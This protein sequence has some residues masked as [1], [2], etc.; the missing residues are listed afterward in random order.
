MNAFIFNGECMWYIVASQ[1]PLYHGRLVAGHACVYQES[2]SLNILIVYAQ[3]F[4][5]FWSNVQFLVPENYFESET[6][7]FS[8]ILFS[9]RII[10]YCSS[11]LRYN[12][13]RL[14]FW[15]KEEFSDHAFFGL[16]SCT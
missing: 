14:V 4:V 8:T 2:E 6:H 13:V 10:L 11:P 16:A 12:N 9:K 1:D 3:S 7:V 15:H 5:I